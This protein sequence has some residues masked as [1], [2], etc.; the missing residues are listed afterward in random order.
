MKLL[1]LENEDRF[2][3]FCL[4]LFKLKYNDEHIQKNGRRGQRQNGVDLFCHKSDQISFWIG[5]QCKVRNSTGISIL[6]IEEEIENAK[7]FNPAISEYVIITT[8]K[9]D[10]KIQEKIRIINTS[11]KYTYFI[12]CLFWED[13]EEFLEEDKYLPVLRKYYSEFF[14]DSFKRGLS[15]GRILTIRLGVDE[16]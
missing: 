11:R 9:R 12:S 5:I 4:D 8:A 16:K 3:S 15:I 13:I 14:I 1:P 2:E 7:T 6:E 10:S